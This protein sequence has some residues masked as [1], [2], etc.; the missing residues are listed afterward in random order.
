MIVVFSLVIITG[1]SGGKQK[2]YEKIENGIAV[3]MDDGK[4]KVQFFEENIVRVVFTKAGEFSERESLSTILRSVEAVDVSIKETGDEI[5][6][7]TEEIK[8]VVSLPTGSIKFVDKS[9]NVVLREKET[10]GRVIEKVEIPWEEAAYSIKQSFIPAA[11]EG[12]YGLGQFQEGVMNWRGHDVDII[13]SN[14]ISVVPCIVS[15]AGY[16]ILWDNYSY[17]KYHDG[18]DGMSFWSEVADEIDYYFVYGP[19]A[20]GVIGGFRDLTGKAPMF[21]KWAYGYF[22]SKEKYA[23]Q[24]ELMSVVREYRKRKLPL[25]VIVQDWWY[26]GK[27]GWSAMKFDETTFPDPEGMMDELHNELNTHIMI[28]IWPKFADISDIYK[29]MKSKGYLYD[30]PDVEGFGTYDAYDKGARDLYWDYVNKGIFSKGMDAWWMDAT[31]PEIG[32]AK[33]QEETMKLIKKAGKCALGSTA[34]YLNAFSLMT[35]LGMYESQ[36]AATDRKR[37]FI[38]TRSGFTGQQRNAAVTWSGDIE[39]E[40]GVLRKQISAGI[41]F[42]MAGIPYWT[43]DIGAFHVRYWEGCKNDEYRELYTRWFQFGTFNPIFRSHGTSTPRE[44]WQFGEPGDWAYEALVKSDR[45]RY[46]LLPYIY[47]LAWKV[48]DED[49]TMMRGLPFDFSGDEN[50][51]GIDDQ[52]MFGPAFLVNPVTKPMY[53]KEKLN[54]ISKMFKD[55]KS[56]VVAKV[57]TDWKL[58]SRKVYLPD[59]EGWIDFWTGE[60]FEGGKEIKAPAPIDRMPLFIKAGSIVPMG[61][62]LQYATEK[63]ADPIEL[64][65]YPGADAEFEIYEDE[66]DNYNYEKGVYSIIPVKW[67]DAGKELTIGNREG[68]FPGM[69]AERVFNIVIVG[70]GHGAGIDPEQAPDRIIEYSGG[71][72]K[73]AF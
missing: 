12:I 50:T 19:D 40:W 9:G 39:A 62:E 32:S 55:T 42:C 20:D 1:C 63:P 37:V 22:Q 53:H 41:N 15:T 66:N 65:I 52:F 16:G 31:E 34:R 47:S 60:K 44:I 25:D 35:T 8:A 5:T 24:E 61:P 29:D 18:D 71:E 48:T 7:G 11:G 64:R 2:S 13:Q 70:T 26:W 68:E 54:E 59:C 10:E 69:L 57:M 36:R 30:V 46:R 4:L 51:Y 58:K 73:A 38:L 23:S 6:V 43:T 17:S 14:T 45:L 3:R 67:D 21:A 56:E 49:Y 33:S 27:Y 72:V 28:S